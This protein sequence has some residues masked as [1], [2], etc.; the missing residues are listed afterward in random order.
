MS[1]LPRHKHKE[2]WQKKLWQTK[3]PMQKLPSPIYPPIRIELYVGSKKNKIWLIYAYDRS[4]GEIVVFVWGKRNLASAKQLREKLSQMG[5]SFDCIRCDN[6][7][8]FLVAFELDNKQIGK[9]FT[10]GIEGNNN[11]I[12]HRIKRAFR[13]TCCFSKRLI[14]HFKINGYMFAICS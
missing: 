10:V 13:R 4:S 7:E 3:L 6:W 9:Q 1:E 8:S 12:R 5:V 14:N 2:K 11:R